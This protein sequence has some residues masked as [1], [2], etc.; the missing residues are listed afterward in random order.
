MIENVVIVVEK[1]VFDR[2]F[3]KTLKCIVEKEKI[4][5]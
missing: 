1:L 5:F 3:F 2:G 4:M